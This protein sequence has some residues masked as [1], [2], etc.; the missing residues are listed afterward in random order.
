VALEN[1]SIFQRIT[2]YLKRPRV[3]HKTLNG[4]PTAKVLEF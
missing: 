3:K 1:N 4:I 2:K